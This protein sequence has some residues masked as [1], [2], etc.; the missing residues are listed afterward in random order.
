[1]AN[2]ADLDACVTLLARFLEDAGSRDYGY[3]SN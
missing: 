1:M 3:E 2:R